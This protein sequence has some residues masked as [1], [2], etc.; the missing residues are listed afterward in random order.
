MVSGPGEKVGFKVVPCEGEVS[1]EGEGEGEAEVVVSG[2]G[3][4]VISGEAV[5]SISS[6]FEVVD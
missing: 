6:P 1:G 2:K 4:V 3:G 5:V